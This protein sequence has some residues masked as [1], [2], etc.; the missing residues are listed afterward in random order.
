M[1]FYIESCSLEKTNILFGS[2]VQLL[3]RGTLE[4]LKVLLQS[5]VRVLSKPL[6]N[7]NILE[8]AKQ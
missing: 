3:H 2:T 8:R 7:L 6:S 4:T 1:V 5:A